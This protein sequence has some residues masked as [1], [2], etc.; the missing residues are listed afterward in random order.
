MYVGVEVKLQMQV[1]GRIGEREKEHVV[2]AEY[3]PECQQN[4]YYMYQPL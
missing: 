3:I 2:R 1:T 4:G